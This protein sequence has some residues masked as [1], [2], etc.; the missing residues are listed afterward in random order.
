MNWG[1]TGK[2]LFYPDGKDPLGDKDKVLRGW[3]FSVTFWKA[4]GGRG[5]RERKRKMRIQ[6]W[7]EAEKAWREGEA[8]DQE[9]GMHRSL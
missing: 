8:H 6:A 7:K 3:A 2:V 4:K 1:G 9:A 5:R